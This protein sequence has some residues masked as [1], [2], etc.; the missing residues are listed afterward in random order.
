MYLKVIWTDFFHHNMLLE[1][2]IKGSITYRS[3]DPVL[4]RI[5]VP[6]NNAKGLC[7]EECAMNHQENTQDCLS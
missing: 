6:Q 2:K 4:V 5:I 1:V 3:L 7:P